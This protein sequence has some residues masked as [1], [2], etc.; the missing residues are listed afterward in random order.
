MAGIRAAVVKE[1]G[2]P[3]PKGRHIDGSGVMNRIDRKGDDGHFVW[4]YQN[5]SHARSLY[6]HAGYVPVERTDDGPAPQGG[7]SVPMGQPIEFMG[8]VLMRCDREKYEQIVRTG[9]MGE[10]GLDMIDER[11]KAIKAAGGADLQGISAPH[12]RLERDPSL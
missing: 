7:T 2:R 4:V 9:H 8:H 11:M 10:T 3:D 5:D 12:A 1:G 6:T